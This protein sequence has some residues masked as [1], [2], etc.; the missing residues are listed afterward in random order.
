LVV[1]LVVKMQ[2]V[3]GV[4]VDIW[5]RVSAVYEGTTG[6]PRWEWIAMYQDWASAKAAWTGMGRSD[7]RHGRS[8]LDAHLATHP[9]SSS[10]P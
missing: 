4:A 8:D 5:G 10:S 6:A 1:V 7:R 9:C 3:V 2:V